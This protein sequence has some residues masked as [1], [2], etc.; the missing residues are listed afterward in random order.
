MKTHRRDWIDVDLDG[1]DKTL[2][3]RT[4]LVWLLHELLA[5]AYDTNATTAAVTLKPVPGKPLAELIVEDD[6]PDGFRDLADAYTLYAESAKKVDPSKRGRW[7]AGEKLVL[8]RCVTAAVISTTGTVSF[9]PDG[10]KHSV[11]RTEA[12]TIFAAVVRMTREELEDVLEK[13]HLVIP[14]IPT[15]ING[16]ALRQREPVKSFELALPTEVADTEGYLRRTV[17][18][19]TVHVYDGPGCIYELGIPVVE[20]GDPWGVSVEQKVPLNSD[21]D[22][23]TP[24]YL[25]ELRVAVVN[26]MH[27][28]LTPE[29]AASPAVQDALTDER[30]EAAAVETILTQQYGDKRAVYDPSDPE[31]NNRLVAEGYT[32]IH[33][34]ALS[35]DAW[36]NVRVSGAA[37]PSGEIRPTPKPYGIE[38]DPAV[39]IPEAEWTAGMQNLAEYACE[40]AQ[41]LTKRTIAVRFERKRLRD[42]WAA[43]YGSRTLTFNYDRLGK[44]YFER[45][46][47]AEFNDLLIHELAH[48]YESNHLSEGYYNACTRLGAKLTDLA[49][50]EPELFRQ[51]GWGAT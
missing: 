24:A 21:R 1:L 42:G 46:V 17:R 35:K 4:G 34:G 2:T 41:R 19:T 3:R 8:A 33:G 12:G 29:T 20:T 11:K 5:N 9:G 48:E 38:G 6:D 43:N 49:L 10:R 44:A 30:I 51:H 27:D 45:G 28:Q 14:P 18:K 7:N 25:R 40:V 23:V 16:V 39:F 50:R 31:A 13:I 47:D 36:K 22:N 37:L 32:L 26:R 15:T